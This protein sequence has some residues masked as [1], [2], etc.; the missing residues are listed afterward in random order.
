VW[1]PALHQEPS[2]HKA[3]ATGKREVLATGGTQETQVITQGQLTLTRVDTRTVGTLD[4][5]LDLGDGGTSSLTGAWD[6]PICP[7]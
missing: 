5:T 6:A 3:A 1:R 7:L 4:A 2:L